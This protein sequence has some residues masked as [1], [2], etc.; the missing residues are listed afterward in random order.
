MDDDTVCEKG[1]V[2]EL[3]K[4]E[5]ALANPSGPNELPEGGLRAW[6]VVAGV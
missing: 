5:E 1:G 2:I 6:L 3:S 4:V